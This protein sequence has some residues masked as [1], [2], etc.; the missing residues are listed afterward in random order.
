MK[1]DQALCM[2]SIEKAELMKQA[3]SYVQRNST[4]KW[5]DAFLKDLKQAYKPS[6]VSYYLGEQSVTL[7]FSVRVIHQKTEMRKLNL[8]EADSSFANSNKCVLFVDHEAL[9]I[10]EYAKDSM[11]PTKQILDDLR[12]IALDSRNTV[13]VFS[14]QCKEVMSSYF[15]Q[16]DYENIWLVAESGYLY[17]EGPNSHWKQLLSL[18]NKIWHKTVLELMLMYTENVD[19]SIVEERESTLVWNYKNAEEEQGNMVAKEVYA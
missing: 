6:S 11:A 15:N 9:P 12:E 5:V 8:F 16:E 7:D 10:L 2:T 18:S 14:N 19:G 13:I 3:Y 4:T 17:K 1:L